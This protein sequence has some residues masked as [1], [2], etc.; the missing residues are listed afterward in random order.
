MTLNMTAPPTRSLR[1]VAS[2]R[3]VMCLIENYSAGVLNEWGLDWETVHEW[4]PKLV[5]V[6][7]SGCGHDGPWQHVISYA[8][9][10]HAVCGLTHLTNFA[11]RGDIGPGFS[12]NDHLAGFSAAVTTLAALEARERTGRGQKVD[13]AQLEIGTYAIGPALIDHFANGR[14]PEP[15]GNKDGLHGLRAKTMSTPQRMALLRCRL[16]RMSSGRH[17]SRSSATRWTIR[18]LATSQLVGSAARRSTEQCRPGF[19]G[20]R[21]MSRWRPCKLPAF[22]QA[23]CNTRATCSRVIHS[24][25]SEDFGR[26][27]TT[28]CSVLAT[29][30][31]F[32]ALLDGERLA[33]ERL[34]P[35]YLGEHNFEV[36]TELAGYEFD[37]VA[38]GMGNDLFS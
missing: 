34:S 30:T 17:S 32:P 7:M 9:T 37:A 23:R 33:V 10:I 19:R 14:A 31:T 35:A 4:N 3:T 12:L 1:P 6:T 28:T 36:W 11:D 8:P 26:P 5:Y 18:P 13:M 16:H 25:L 21:P 38:E 15:D 27:R 20:A 24:M 22:R 29:S 2:S